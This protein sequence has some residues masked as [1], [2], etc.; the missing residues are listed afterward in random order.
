[1]TKGLPSTVDTIRQGTPRAEGPASEDAEVS[2]DRFLPV[3]VLGE[4][5]VG[6]VMSY[7]DSALDRRVAVKIARQDP[8]TH[9]IPGLVE[10]EA[11]I[12]GSLEHPSIIPVYDVGNHPEW[13]AYYVMRLVQQPSLEDELAKLRRGDPGHSRGRLLRFFIQVCQAIDY[14]HSRGVVHCDLKPDNILLGPFGEVFVADW[15]FAHRIG[16]KATFGGGTA[17]FMPPEQLS[18]KQDEIDGRTDVFALGA[19]LYQIL[20]DERAFPP[21]T[22]E[23]WKEARKKGDPDPLTPPLPPSER[24]PDRLVPPDLE[25]VCLKAIELDRTKRLKSAGEIAAALDTFLEGT[26]ARKRKLRH[27][28]ELTRNGDGLVEVHGDLLASRPERLAELA[29]LR[30]AIPPWETGE[31]KDAIWDAEDRLAV[32][33]SLAART[34]QAAVSAFEHALD[35]VP[36]HAPARRGLA[37]LYW[38]EYQRALG[39]GNDFDRP[40]FEALALEY[41]DGTLSQTLN[42]GGNLTIDCLPGPAEVIVRDVVEQ[43][44]RRVPGRE[45]ERGKAPLALDLDGGVY[46]VTVERAGEAPIRCPMFVRPGVEHSLVVDL[47]GARPGEGEVLIPGGKALVGGHESNPW[48]RERLEV[49]VAPFLLARLPVTFAEYLAFVAHLFGTDEALAG[50]HLPRSDDGEAFFRWDG[51]G[52]L[53]GTIARWGVD[54]A[55]AMA[56]P[57]F[58][59][60][61]A[62]ALAYAEWRSTVEGKGY[63]LPAEWEWEKAARGVDGRPYPW[64]S[65][66]DASFCKMRDSR[67]AAP[68]PEA[69]G[70]FAVDESPYGV[71]DRAWGVADWV[72]PMPG[73]EGLRAISKGGAWCDWMTDCHAAA[74]RACLPG[75]RSARVGFRL[76]RDAAASG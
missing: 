48:A 75:E 45:R 31:R 8:G 3:G 73:E 62:S 19:I 6:K 10:R 42:K 30:A 43:G 57:V 4:G 15:G 44:A 9:P 54:A 11:L 66:F 47:R 25:E 26:K 5:G 52:W 63:R 71:R 76:A 74:R 49:E 61:M 64:G 70:A 18:R 50:R 56:M 58:G 24:A 37:R 20:T 72:K 23:L 13:G 21:V 27:A 69:V 28:E 40:R 39:Q 12:T 59:V 1:M 65:R 22:F 35:E 17:G 7:Y 55:G 46:A 14:A 51:G 36:D 34:F 41:D 16:Q 38:G 2:G 68:A 29:E 33:D 60:E 53:P 32:L 67:G